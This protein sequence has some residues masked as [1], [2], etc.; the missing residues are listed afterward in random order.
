MPSVSLRFAKLNRSFGYLDGGSFQAL[1]MNY[2][3]GDLSMVMLLPTATDGLPAFEQSLTAGRLSDW[4]SQLS[5]RQVNVTIPAFQSTDKVNM[6]AVLSSL[7]MTDAFGSLADF[8]GIAPGRLQISSVLQKTVI[9]VD[10]EGTQAASVTDITMRIA[11]V[12][13]QPP[14]VEFD[15]NHPFIYLIRDN[16]SGAILFMG[17]VE[18]PTAS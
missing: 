7:G 4:L 16:Q 15:A 2:Q 1:S 12:I 13:A 17:R 5:P 8:S 9:K 18:D 11:A 6:A 3:G 14:P 10:E